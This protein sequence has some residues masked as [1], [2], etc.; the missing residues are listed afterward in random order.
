MDCLERRA[1]TAAGNNKLQERVLGFFNSGVVYSQMYK[2]ARRSF[3]DKKSNALF[4]A[5]D[6]HEE[7]R[8]KSGVYWAGAQWVA[9]PSINVKE[10]INE[11]F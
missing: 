1:A 10:A 6:E 4:Q 9:A 11:D 7:L 5:N 8:R 3:T 2:M